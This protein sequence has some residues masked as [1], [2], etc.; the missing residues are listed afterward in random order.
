ML[1]Y[2][3]CREKKGLKTNRATETLPDEMVYA[4]T[5]PDTVSSMVRRTQHRD[6]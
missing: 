1:E 3:S 2:L 5:N 4:R 6:L